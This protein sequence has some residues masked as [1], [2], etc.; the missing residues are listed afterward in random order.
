[1]KIEG[2][3]EVDHPRAEVW[4]KIRDPQVMGG[5]I[6]GCD[7]V[8]QVDDTSYRVK[9]SVKVGPIKA[10]FNL[11]VEVLEEDPPHTIVSRTSGEEG[12]RSS[13]VNSDNV[14]RLAET[15]T[16]GTRVDYIADVSVTGRLGKFGLGI[17][18]KKADQLAEQFVVNFRDRLGVAQ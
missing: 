15:G 11:S 17:F 7:S 5:C 2:N 1:M 9:V 18:R 6:P 16:G 4:D 14:V 8:E 10:H 12:T 3:F 13:V